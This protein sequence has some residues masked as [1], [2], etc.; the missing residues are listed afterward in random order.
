MVSK[1]TVRFL[2]ASPQK[3][4]LI[5]DQI[6]GRDV[7]DALAVLK[8]SRRRVARS[9]EKLLGSAIANS[10]QGEERID[11]D[12]LYVSKA[13]VDQGPADKRGRAGTMGRFLPV[14]HRRSHIT[15]QLDVRQPGGKR[16]RG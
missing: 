16:R 8:V 2:K 7:D 6:R 10:Q 9:V 5:V 3:A 4:R 15:V 12:R 11:V 1:A 13:W 14:L